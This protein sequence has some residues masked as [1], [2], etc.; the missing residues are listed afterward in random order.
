MTEVSEEGRLARH[1]WGTVIVFLAMFV[2]LVSITYEP[3]LP[4]PEQ[5]LVT[6]NDTRN[7][8]SPSRKPRKTKTIKKSFVKNERL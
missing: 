7:L 2:G 6:Q 1:E 8:E 3:Y 5:E 4:P